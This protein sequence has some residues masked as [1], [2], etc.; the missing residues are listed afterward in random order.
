MDEPLGRARWRLGLCPDLPERDKKNETR[1]TLLT[2]AWGLS[3]LAAT[4]FLSADTTAGLPMR[5]GIAI[6]PTLI[7]IAAIA[8][9]VRFVREADELIRMIHL[10]SLALGFGAGMLFMLGY[11]LFERI[12]APVLDMDDALLA[13][14]LVWAGAQFLL[15]RR[16]A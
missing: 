7:G 16:Y 13:M 4:A 6:V 3:F 15:S 14:V 11:R 9:Y 2:A 10:V 8:A 5:A 1:F 12:G